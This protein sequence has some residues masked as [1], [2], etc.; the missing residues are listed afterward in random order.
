MPLYAA[1]PTQ[2]NIMSL[3]RS[4]SVHSLDAIVVHSPPHR[5]IVMFG[6]LPDTKSELDINWQIWVQT[7]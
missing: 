5:F 4:S 1:H 2:V 7:V 3:S 6:T